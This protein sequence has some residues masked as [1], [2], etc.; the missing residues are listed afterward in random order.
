MS[1]TYWSSVAGSETE[2]FLN[3][4]AYGSGYS[5]G[6]SSS[7]SPQSPLTRPASRPITGVKHA[8]PSVP[9][10][11][12]VDKQ[13]GWKSGGNVWG[14]YPGAGKGTSSAA[15]AHMVAQNY[16]QKEKEWKE[17][18]IS[19][20]HFQH[21]HV[22]FPPSGFRQSMPSMPRSGAMGGGNARPLMP[23]QDWQVGSSGGGWGPSLNF[24]A[25]RKF[26]RRR[27]RQPPL[28]L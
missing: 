17:T 11:K 27:G 28:D 5:S 25:A 9:F 12:Q 15:V 1:S 2:S 14:P 3:G 24:H 7:G 22:P 20:A 6:G 4:S 8:Q 26:G 18:R 19:A 21:Q 16:G 23:H 10:C 13:P